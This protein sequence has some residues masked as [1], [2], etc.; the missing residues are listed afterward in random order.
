M[1]DVDPNDPRLEPTKGAGCWFFVMP[2]AMAAILVGGY[3]TLCMAGWYGHPA[4]GDRVELVF[5]ACPEAKPVLEARVAEMGL[6]TPEWKLDGSTITL[7]A[8]LP[9]D[10]ALAA[11]IP[12]T[13]A[14]QG[15][16][17][18]EPEGG[19]DPL[20]TAANID[21][22][23]IRLDIVANPGTAII[24][25]ADAKDAIYQAMKA[26]P[27]GKLVGRIDGVQVW[28]RKNYPPLTEGK[29]EIETDKETLQEGTAQ[30]AE[31][32]ILLNNGEHPCT[33]ALHSNRIVEPALP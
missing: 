27:E 14:A 18:I 24:L 2:I 6:G 13:L 1:T 29:L 7:T 22:A 10:E 4:S 17:L 16:F 12:G 28:E 23:R 8:T 30:T 9:G 31:W 5:E 11:G 25:D 19:G 21:D 3:G 20:A 32:G 33:V 26:D 15:A